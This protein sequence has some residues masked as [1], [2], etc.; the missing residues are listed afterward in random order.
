[1]LSKTSYTVFCATNVLLP[2]FLKYQINRHD[3]ENESQQMVPF[4]TLALKHEMGDDGEDNQT[5]ALLDDFELHQTEGTAVAVEAYAVGRHLAAV[6]EE[7]DSPREG[8]DTD[9]RPV[10]RNASALKFQV[11]IPSQCHEDV[12]Q[13]QE[14]NRVK[15][16]H[17]LFYR[18]F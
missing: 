7:G 10:A 12:A 14:Q 5:Y 18:G 11:A 2:S 1:M 9:E 17:I 16:C 6:F 3:E 4:Q 13:N 8:Y 15:A